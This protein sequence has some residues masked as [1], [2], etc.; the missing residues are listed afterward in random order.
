MIGFGRIKNHSHELHINWLICLHLSRD[1]FWMHPNQSQDKC[2]QISQ[3]I[4]H[5]NGFGCFQNQSYWKMKF[6]DFSANE[7]GFGCIQNQSLYKCKQISQ[8][9]AHENGFGCIQN[10]SLNRCKQTSQ[11]IADERS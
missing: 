1:L 10:Q 5:E 3:F 4:A 11:F 8:L 6:T 2:K 7:N 9:I